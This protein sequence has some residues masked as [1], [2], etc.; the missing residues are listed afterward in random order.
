MKVPYSYNQLLSDY[1]VLMQKVNNFRIIRR[2]AKNTLPAD[3]SIKSI[4]FEV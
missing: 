2:A 3:E 4:A 1:E